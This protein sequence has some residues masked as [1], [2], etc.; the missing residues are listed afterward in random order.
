MPIDLRCRHDRSLRELAADLLEG[1][2]SPPVGQSA[3]VPKSHPPPTARSGP[4]TQNRTLPG[5][6]GHRT[7]KNIPRPR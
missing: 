6:G 2:L 4:R 5:P 3:P 7:R 1:G